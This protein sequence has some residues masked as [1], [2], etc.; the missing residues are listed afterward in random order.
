MIFLSLLQKDSGSPVIYDNFLVG[1]AIFN[2]KVKNRV[3]PITFMRLDRLN[4]YFQ[5][6]ILK[7]IPQNH[8][9]NSIK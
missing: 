9:L 2:P 4:E 5:E 3:P 6:M 1:I 8:S 7:P